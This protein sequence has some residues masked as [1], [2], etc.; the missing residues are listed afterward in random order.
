MDIRQERE[1]F[2]LNYGKWQIEERE[3]WDRFIGHSTETNV[4]LARNKYED[5]ELDYKFDVDEGYVGTLSDIN[6]NRSYN[7]E[8]IYVIA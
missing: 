6:N 5:T 2:P 8:Q 1:L 3:K 7:G 4:E